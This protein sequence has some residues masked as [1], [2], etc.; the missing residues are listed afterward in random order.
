VGAEKKEERGENTGAVMKV[1]KVMKKRRIQSQRNSGRLLNQRCGDRH[2]RWPRKPGTNK[3][4]AWLA[5]GS[6]ALGGDLFPEV[7]CVCELYVDS[8]I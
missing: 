6:R 8:L 4:A 3:A 2:S 5:Q 1:M 7:L